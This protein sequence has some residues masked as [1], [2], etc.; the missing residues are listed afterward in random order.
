MPP[1]SKRIKYRDRPDAIKGRYFAFTLPYGLFYI[2]GAGVGYSKSGNLFCLIISGFLGILFVLLS[3]AHMIDYYR[4]VQLESYF[5]FIPF[6]ISVFVGIL[7]TCVWALGGT[8]KS[9]G[10]VALA[11]GFAVLFYFYAIVKDYGSGSSY[12][13]N[14]WYKAVPMSSREAG[15]GMDTEVTSSSGSQL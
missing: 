15:F 6:T 2:V 14:P 12:R 8:F 4:G 9:S 7:M 3:L 11:A 5:V 10:I 1:I 13:E